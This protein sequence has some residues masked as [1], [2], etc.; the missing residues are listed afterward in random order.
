MT[1]EAKHNHDFC[2]DE[3]GVCAHG[4]DSEC[5]ALQEVPDGPK[6]GYCQTCGQYP[7]TPD[8]NNPEPITENAVLRGQVATLTKALEDL[9]IRCDGDEVVRADGSNI[10]TIAAHALLDSHDA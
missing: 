1:S 6:S 9:A 4:K 7:K 3:S 5:P 2:P 8:L 10:Q